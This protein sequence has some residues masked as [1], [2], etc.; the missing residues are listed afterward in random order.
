[1]KEI[2]IT[3][4]T[5]AELRNLKRQVDRR[6]TSLGNQQSQVE[7]QPFQ[8]G[9]RVVFNPKGYPIVRGKVKRFNKK[10]VTVISDSGQRWNVAPHLLKKAVDNQF[11]SLKPRVLKA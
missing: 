6:L 5:L 8:L 7:M 1:M 2:D 11:V 4:F 10:D 3:Q 9:D